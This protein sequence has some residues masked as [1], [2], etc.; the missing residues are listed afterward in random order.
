MIKIKKIYC[1]LVVFIGSLIMKW[2]LDLPKSS[3][4]EYCEVLGASAL[5]IISGMILAVIC[6]HFDIVTTAPSAV[7]VIADLPVSEDLVKQFETDLYNTE[8]QK[9][10]ALSKKAESDYTDRVILVVFALSFISTVWS[11]FHP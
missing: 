2:I 4:E 11:A 9:Q 5:G 8:A 3:F 10:A 1:Y 6:I 7:S